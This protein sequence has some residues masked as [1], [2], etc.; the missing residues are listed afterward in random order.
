MPTDKYSKVEALT[1]CLNLWK[2]IVENP[3]VYKKSALDSLTDAGVIKE[4]KH[5]H[6]CPCCTYAETVWL[7]NTQVNSCGHCPLAG[8]AW[9]VQR[10][11]ATMCEH[12][13]SAYY[14]YRTSTFNYKGHYAAEIV[15]ACEQALKDIEEN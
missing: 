10:E 7:G 1:D 12:P 9:E 6:A 8:Y 3:G 2:Y 11:V 15:S 5:S 13:G 14:G 4:R